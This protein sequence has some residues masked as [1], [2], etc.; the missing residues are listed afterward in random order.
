[1][2]RIIPFE[3]ALGTKGLGFGVKV[4]ATVHE[5][6]AGTQHDAGRIFSS[7][8]HEGP[9]GQANDERQ[10]CAHSQTLANGGVQV[11][12]PIE[13]FS[14]RRRTAG[15]AV[16]FVGDALHHVGTRNDLLQRPGQGDGGRVV[17]GDDQSQEGV[18]DFFI[19]Q[20]LAIVVGGG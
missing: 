16:Q 4:R 13:M 6:T 1:M 2:T 5:V 20:W 3:K 17:S 18:A 10:N 14:A 15:R 7:A 8:S 12:Q 19:R 9:L 11:L